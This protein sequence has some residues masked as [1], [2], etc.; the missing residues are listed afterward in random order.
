M[1]IIHN[2]FFVEMK[3][4][5]ILFTIPNFDS[6]GSGKALLN[7]AMG[8]NKDQFE[9][10]ILCLHKRGV[11]FETVEKSGILMH[12]FNYLPCERPLW[13]MLYQSFVVAI[14][15]RKINPA[16]IH[17]YNYSSNYTEGLS[18]RIAGIKW[19][20]TK[21]NM[22]W[23]GGSKRYWVLRSY[24]ATKI[25]VQNSDM[26]KQF[27]AESKKTF[28]LPRGVDAAK[29]ASTI[30]KA[31][32][33][34]AMNTH[35]DKRIIICV[36]NFVPVKGIEILVEA[37]ELLK[38]QYPDWV[39]WLIGD[40]SNE[41][42]TELMELVKSKKLQDKIIFSGKKSNVI[43]FLTHAEIFVLPTKDKGEGTPVAIL[44]AMANGKVVI[45]SSVP[46][47]NDQL[48]DFP[49]HLF[50]ASNTDDLQHKLEVFMKNTFAEN[51]NIGQQFKNLVETE[52][53]IENEIRNHELLYLSI[54]KK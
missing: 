54:L 28:L 15:F 48:R 38:N 18:A 51:K 9:P 23:G 12:A 41:Y 21:K 36:A 20:F 5:K 19:V 13:R 25:A 6:A 50:E 46:G 35:S 31:E 45:G 22:S 24:F 32:I 53:T 27:Y 2:L 37:F 16:I 10:H 4:V 44:E 34:T 11:F 29:F 39:V 47:I 17:S 8:L 3:K 49:N 14:K 30:P 42:G 52:F 40:T 7:I 26:I 1:G 43:D 33:R